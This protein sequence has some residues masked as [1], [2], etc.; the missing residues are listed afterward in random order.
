[1]TGADGFIGS[2]LVDALLERVTEAKQDAMDL[3]HWL[4]TLELPE[5]NQDFVSGLKTTGQ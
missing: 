2:H 4:D 3:I 1:M 5:D